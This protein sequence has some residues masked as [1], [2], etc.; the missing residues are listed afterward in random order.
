MPYLSGVLTGVILTI[1]VVF[2]IDHVEDDPASQDV[3]NWGLIAEGLETTV[4]DVNEEVRKE[5]HE[6]TAP[7]TDPTPAATENPPATTDTSDIQ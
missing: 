3:V 2:V 4:A 1:L 7:E 5:L 6:A